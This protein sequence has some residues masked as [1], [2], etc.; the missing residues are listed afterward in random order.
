MAQLTPEPEMLRNADML[1]C[2]APSAQQSTLALDRRIWSVRVR[3]SRT[4][5]S[6]TDRCGSETMPSFGKCRV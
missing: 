1:A 5:V 3:R 6:A 2:H 4:L